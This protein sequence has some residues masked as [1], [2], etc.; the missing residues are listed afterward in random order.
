MSFPANSV[1]SLDSSDSDRL[2]TRR[3]TPDSEHASPTR[4]GFV[5]GKQTN[6]RRNQT[7][8]E[9]PMKQKKRSTLLGM[10]SPSKSKATKSKELPDPAPKKRR[11]RTGWYVF[12]VVVIVV[13]FLPFNLLRLSTETSVY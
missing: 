4:Q 7:K 2:P 6:P 9:K 12:F 11:V 10:T 13:V 1:L 8:N 5:K 3:G